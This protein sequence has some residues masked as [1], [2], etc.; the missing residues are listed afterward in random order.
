MTYIA[1][2]RLTT[3]N[4]PTTTQHPTL[5]VLCTRSRSN[6]PPSNHHKAPEI[7]ACIC[8][9][10]WVELFF[11]ALKPCFVL[12][13]ERWQNLRPLRARDFDGMQCRVLDDFDGHF[14]IVWPFCLLS[15]VLFDLA[16]SL[17]RSTSISTLHLLHSVDYSW[18]PSCH[19]GQQKWIFWE[20]FFDD[21]LFWLRY[22]IYFLN[23]MCRCLYV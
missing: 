13:F 22:P 23:S 16:S 19:P 12:Q 20:G 10:Y 1:G 6:H 4:L 15:S 2:H 5:P 7:H 9:I 3:P 21:R 18:L 17:V 8:L 11:H 14:P